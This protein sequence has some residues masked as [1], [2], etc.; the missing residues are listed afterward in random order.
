MIAAVLKVSGMGAIRGELP[1]TFCR[2]ILSSGSFMKENYDRRN[3]I[4]SYCKPRDCHRP[5]SDVTT[6]APNH[7]HRLALSKLLCCSRIHVSAIILCST[8]LPRSRPLYPIT[9]SVSF[10]KHL[11]DARKARPKPTIVG[12]SVNLSD[13]CL[14]HISFGIQLHGHRQK[15]SKAVPKLGNSILSWRPHF[16]HLCWSRR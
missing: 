1:R 12:R 13:G 7:H 9:T 14:G 2:R 11:L 3:Y 6:N 5:G 16:P 10:P 15:L 4:I 8:V